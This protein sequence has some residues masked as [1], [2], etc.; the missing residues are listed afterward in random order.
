MLK[1]RRFLDR[2]S[3]SPRKT[4]KVFLALLNYL[5][6]FSD[7][8]PIRS[9]VSEFIEGYRAGNCVRKAPDLSQ[10]L[11][12]LTVQASILGFIDMLCKLGLGLFPHLPFSLVLSH[13]LPTYRAELALLFTFPA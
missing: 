6:P 7:N 10:C 8:H 13:Y 5:P 11:S 2:V 4:G 9:V 12:T 3:Q 1:L